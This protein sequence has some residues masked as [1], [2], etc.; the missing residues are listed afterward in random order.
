MLGAWIAV[1]CAAAA[2]AWGT[3]RYFRDRTETSPDGRF[4]LDA[5][6][7]DNA[8]PGPHPFAKHFVYTM[9][10][11]RTGTVVWKRSQHREPSPIG[12]WVHNSGAVAVRTSSDTLIVLDGVTGEKT[13][14]APILGSIPEDEHEK[15]VSMS[16]AGPMWSGGSRWTFFEQG[17]GLYFAV[18]AW[19][20]RLLIVDTAT[21]KLVARPPTSLVDAFEAEDR[22]FVLTALQAGAGR[23]TAPE[24][25]RQDLYEL[26]YGDLGTA[27]QLAARYG[28]ADA[29]PALRQLEM[30]SYVG[31]SGGWW[32]T[33]G[34]YQPGEINPF[35]SREATL[36][37]KVQLALRRLGEK[38]A[39]EPCT[40]FAIVGEYRPYE[41]TST[42]YEPMGP[43]PWPR[44]EG[45]EKFASGASPMQVLDAIGAPDFIDFQL[46][47]WEYDMDVK[48]PYTLRVYW[49]DKKTVDRS[50]R[51]TP[52]LWQ[53]TDT[54]DRQLND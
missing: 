54:R 14:E 47:A 26:E 45:V 30:S 19:W 33:E 7:P 35:N 15:Y 42:L 22:R 40:W 41:P 52:A 50:E 44:A 3:D 23:L 5:R 4:R 48:P 24:A 16:T 34:V 10:D 36:R 27:A 39:E 20:G 32:D 38:P 2:P 46:Q 37:R 21:G 49:K 51:I 53:Q 28:L 8:G 17:G 18:R 29:V 13:G 43:L 31:S 25:S 11:T 6:S 9:T 12:A 1:V